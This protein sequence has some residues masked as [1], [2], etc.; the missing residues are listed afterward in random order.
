MSRFLMRVLNVAQVRV[1]LW[2][3]SFTRAILLPPLHDPRVRIEHNVAR[4]D[5]ADRAH[6]V[7]QDYLVVG[8]H[9][10]LL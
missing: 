8:G 9:R 4:W 7:E 5:R 3:F 1:S 10:L 6:N 2:S